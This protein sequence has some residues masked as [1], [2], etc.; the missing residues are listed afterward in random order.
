MVS[1]PVRI[2]LFT[3]ADPAISPGTATTIEALFGHLPEDV[4]LAKYCVSASALAGL[5]LRPILDRARRDRIDVVH[6]AAC[7]P[8]AIAGIC[9]GWR[10][11]LPV[12]GSFAPDFGETPL[13]AAYLRV[14]AGHCDSLFAA[15]L[16]AHARLAKTGIDAARIV[17]WRPAVDTD[18]FTPARRSAALRER[19][20]V[21]DSRPAVVYAGALSEKKCALRLLALEIGLHR[22]HPMHRLIVVGDGPSRAEIERRCPHALFMGAVPR[23]DLPAILASADLFVCPS[24]A[25]STNHGVLE[26]Q[27]SGLPAVVMENGSARERVSKWSGIVCRSMVDMIVET[28]ALIR[29]DDRRLAMGRAAREHARLQ[30]GTGGLSAVYAEYRA[31]ATLSGRRRDLGPTLV[32]QS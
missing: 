8:A 6:L 31:A 27:A 26:A 14:L 7:G 19:W 10:L 17:S 15:S 23:R 13:R 29:T 12:L 21:S 25:C 11:K 28:A 16:A 9:V 20:Q 18:L 5:W 30:H 2:A 3:E 22:T 32:S 24:E 1:H 4:E